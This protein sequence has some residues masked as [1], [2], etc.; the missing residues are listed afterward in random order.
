MGLGE[1]TPPFFLDCCFAFLGMCLVLFLVFM[2]VLKN[3]IV[4]NILEGVK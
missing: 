3:V 1:L 4:Y 2:H